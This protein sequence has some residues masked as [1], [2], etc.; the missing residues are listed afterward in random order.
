[1]LKKDFRSKIFVEMNPAAL[2]E[3]IKKEGLSDKLR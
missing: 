1:L 3:K 2:L